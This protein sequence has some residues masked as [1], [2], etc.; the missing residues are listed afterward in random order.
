M[1]VIIEYFYCI[2]EDGKEF[3]T[4]LKAKRKKERERESEKRKKERRKNFVC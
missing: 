3:K 4:E 2:I 1:G